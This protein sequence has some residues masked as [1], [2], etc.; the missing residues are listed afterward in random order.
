MP[1]VVVLGG[2]GA[3]RRAMFAS[4]NFSTSDTIA[5]RDSILSLFNTTGINSLPGFVSSFTVSPN[6]ASDHVSIKMDLKEAAH[7]LI[8]LTDITGKSIAIVS[9]EK[10][11]GQVERQFNTESLPNGNY[12][13]RIRVNGKSATQRL[14]VAH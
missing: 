4:F 5:M 14:T 7:L 13:V 2:S 12:F 11:N 8:E 9:D 1:T 3:N 6:P 10:H